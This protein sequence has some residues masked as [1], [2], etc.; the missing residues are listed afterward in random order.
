ML[1]KWLVSAIAVACAIVLFDG[2]VVRAQPVDTLTARQK[3]FRYLLL[4]GKYRQAHQLS[5][6]NYSLALQAH[7]AEHTVVATSLNDLADI[8]RMLG[9][10]D[11]AEVSYKRALSMREQI[12][13]SEHRDVATVLN[14]LGE[15]YDANGRYGDAE[16]LLRRALA[17]RE[18]ALG[19][20]DPD[21]AVCG[22]R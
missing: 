20:D 10:Y 5:E 19:S 6:A 13:G 9:N 17:I 21:V 22:G 15:L 14:G 2:A 3:E 1:Q 4:L 16:D 12:L 7:G 8:Q 11:G 18:Q